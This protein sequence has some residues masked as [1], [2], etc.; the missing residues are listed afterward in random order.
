MKEAVRHKRSFL[1]KRGRPFHIS[2]WK[3]TGLII[4]AS[5]KKGQP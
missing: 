3:L 1:G 2:I 4:K 5:E